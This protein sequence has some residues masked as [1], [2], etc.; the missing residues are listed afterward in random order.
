MRGLEWRLETAGSRPIAGC[1]NL[2]DCLRLKGEHS[3]VV[4][5]SSRMAHPVTFIPIE[6]YRLIGLAQNQPPAR[7]LD[8]QPRTGEYDLVST[9]LLLVPTPVA[10]PSAANV[11]DRDEISSKESFGLKV[12]HVRLTPV[13]VTG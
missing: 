6:K 12:R 11:G 13:T 1:K 8:E 5:D 4:P 3:A 2:D 7:V 10:R 9:G